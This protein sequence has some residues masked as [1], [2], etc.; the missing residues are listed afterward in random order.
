[1]NTG[2]TTNEKKITFT[3]DLSVYKILLRSV[4]YFKNGRF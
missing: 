2:T 3:T 4:K 1:M